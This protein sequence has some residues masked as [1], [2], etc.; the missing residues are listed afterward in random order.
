MAKKEREFATFTGYSWDA[1]YYING[2]DSSYYDNKEAKENAD[3][4]LAKLKS[5]Y[6]DFSIVDCTDEPSY[7]LPD[8]GSQKHGDCLEY[9]IEYDSRFTMLS[10]T[11]SGNIKLNLEKIVDRYQIERALMQLSEKYPD[12]SNLPTVID[13][14]FRLIIRHGIWEISIYKDGVK[15]EHSFMNVLHIPA[16]PIERID[17]LEF[18][19]FTDFSKLVGIWID[20]SLFDEPIRLIYHT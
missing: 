13:D 11:K 4:V 5:I 2:D 12:C 6:G 9:T 10:T 7:A 19:F 16:I 20:N 8:F 18:D 3:N 15:I 14:T 1:S 17:T